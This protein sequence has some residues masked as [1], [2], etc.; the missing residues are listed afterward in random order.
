MIMKAKL[1]SVTGEQKGEVELPKVFSAKINLSLIKK[2]VEAA[3]SSARQPYGADPLAGKRSSAHYHGK[4][5]YRF[6]MMNREMSRQPRIHGKVGHL[7][8]TARVAP[9]A[10]KGRKAH[11]PKAEKI[12]EKKL[13]KKEEFAA[14]RSALSASVVPDMIKARGHKFHSPIVFESAFEALD[15]TSKVKSALEVLLKEEMKRCSVKKVRAGTGKTRGRKYRRKKGPVVLLPSNSPLVRFGRNIPG[16]DFVA[17]DNITVEHLA[18][19]TQPG[20]LLVTTEGALS[21]LEK[22]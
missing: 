11:P 6:T 15:K 14:L 12:W 16:F 10:V 3:Q 21:A 7:G 17:V 20:R 1:Y 22:W 8:F 13:N 18:P 4:R 5:H 2:A 19:G 9:H